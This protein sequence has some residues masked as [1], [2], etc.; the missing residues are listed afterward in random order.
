MIQSGIVGWAIEDP[1]A[2]EGMGQIRHHRFVT[3]EFL[4]EA[5]D[6]HPLPIGCR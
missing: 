2:I 1:A 5:V 4:D 6:N 3:E